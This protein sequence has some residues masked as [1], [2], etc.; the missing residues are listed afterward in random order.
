MAGF[1]VLLEV[2][3]ASEVLRAVGAGVPLPLPSSW[4]WNL[5]LLL[6]LAGDGGAAVRPDR[7]AGSRP[8]PVLLGGGGRH[9][10]RRGPGLA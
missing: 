9:Q 3:R 1:V 8:L 2:C 5:L 6:L 7:H 10:A 4:Q